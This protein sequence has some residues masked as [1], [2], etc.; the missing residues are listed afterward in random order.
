MQFRPHLKAAC[1]AA[2]AAC[3]VVGHAG[4]PAPRPQMNFPVTDRARFDYRLH[5]GGCHRD[6][7]SG[8]PGFVPTLKGQVGSYLWSRDGRAYL[9]QVPGV[10]QSFL[11]D[12]RLAD[13]LNYIVGDFD[14]K[15]PPAGA[16][17][18]AADE[19]GALRKFP[20]SDATKHRRRLRT[21]TSSHPER[22]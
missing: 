4:E 11:S 1:W 22:P 13:V 8:Q 12:V 14:P 5:C 6:D 16:Q 18:F 3:P 7:G 20:L 15:G 21:P 10:A 2:L 19:V 9:V 17:P